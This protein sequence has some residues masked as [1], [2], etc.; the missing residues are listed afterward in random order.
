MRAEFHGKNTTVI[1]WPPDSL[2]LSY[3]TP[4][5]FSTLSSSVTSKRTGY[6]WKH[7]ASN[8]DVFLATVA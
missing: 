7:T 1:T 2:R 4:A 3:I 6:N 5:A 8:K